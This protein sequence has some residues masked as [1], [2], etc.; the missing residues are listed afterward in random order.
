MPCCPCRNLCAYTDQRCSKLTLLA[1]PFFLII[2]LLSFYV[3][4]MWVPLVIFS[5]I[6]ICLACGD[7]S[8]N[9]A[10]RQSFARRNANSTAVQ[11]E[12]TIPVAVTANHPDGGVGVHHIPCFAFERKIDSSGEL[13]CSVCLEVLQNGEMVRQLPACQHLFHVGCIDMWLGSHSTCPLCRSSVEVAK[14]AKATEISQS[15]APGG[16]E[17]AELPV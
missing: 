3:K 11:S 10:I 5:A 6:F 9:I 2:L 15:S 4:F 1:Y 17:P 8:G 12:I 14:T 16:S 13:V 7:W